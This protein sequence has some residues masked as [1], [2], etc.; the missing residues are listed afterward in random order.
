MATETRLFYYADQGRVGLP[1]LCQQ[2]TSLAVVLSVLAG[3]GVAAYRSWQVYAVLKY[4]NLDEGSESARA[5]AV[6]IDKF[7]P[8]KRGK[9]LHDQSSGKV[10]EQHC[11]D[12]GTMK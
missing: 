4:R 7:S 1:R 2:F 5:P 9:I 10:A 11:S 12:Y 3:I 8:L 6:R